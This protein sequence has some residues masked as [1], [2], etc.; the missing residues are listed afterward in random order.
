[1]LACT[2]FTTSAGHG[3]D[4][5][6]LFHERKGSFNALGSW[7]GCYTNSTQPLSQLHLKRELGGQELTP[8]STV[9]CFV[10]FFFKRHRVTFH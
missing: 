7:F 1:M 4:N 9:L 5:P 8:Y 2:V 10:F 3:G 6:R